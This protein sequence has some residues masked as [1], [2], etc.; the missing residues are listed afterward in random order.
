[1]ELKLVEVAAAYALVRLAVSL[2]RVE[3][4]ASVI[5]PSLEANGSLHDQTRQTSSRVSGLD[6]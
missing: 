2:A 6:E 5:L 4:M 1:M 3:V